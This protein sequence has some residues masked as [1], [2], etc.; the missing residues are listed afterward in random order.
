MSMAVDL[1]TPLTQAEREYLQMRGRYDDIT[2]ADEMHGVTDQSLPEGDG[3][4][5][6]L[7]GMASY[8]VRDQR[9]AALEA[10]LALLRGNDA[11]VD[12]EEEVADDVAPY[13]EW[14]VAELDAELKRRGLPVKGDK[15]TKV[16]ALYDHDDV[17]GN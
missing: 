7:H 13:E 12:T 4:G 1:S 6:V 3:T 15:P 16:T 14:T 9:I 8:D 10:E 17:A 2:R 11:P 5:P